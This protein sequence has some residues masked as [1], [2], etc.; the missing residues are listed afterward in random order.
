[1]E[2]LKSLGCQTLDF[3]LVFSIISNSSFPFHEKPYAWFATLFQYP[4]LNELMSK[5]K[6]RILS[7]LKLR[8]GS[9][10][11]VSKYKDIFFP[12]KLPHDKDMG[13]LDIPI[14]H[15]D[16]Y[17][18][19]CGDRS[20]DL[21]LRST[22]QIKELSDGDI[23][24]AIIEYHQRRQSNIDSGP[25]TVDVCLGHAAYLT[26][27]QHLIQGPEL[28]QLKESFHLVD[29]KNHI[30]LGIGNMSLDWKITISETESVWLSE[31]CDNGELYCLNEAYPELS[32]QFIR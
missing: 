19:I 2:I 13:T 29:H 22:L 28:R 5:R 25:F 4:A 9:W 30:V 26:R 20:V 8:N 3:Q 24:R 6:A 1:M 32:V 14:L 21:F 27:R 17:G 16:F 31:V 11:S 7:Y 23:I 15:D 12:S 18:E 10:T